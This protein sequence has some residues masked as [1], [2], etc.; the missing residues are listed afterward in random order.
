MPGLVAYNEPYRPGSRPTKVNTIGLLTAGIQNVKT[1]VYY[2]LPH[3]QLLQHIQNSLACAV[4]K[5]PKFSH[6]TPILKSLNWLKVNERIEYKILSHIQDS[7]HTAQ[8]ADLHNLIS[9]QPPGRTRSSSLIIIARP[10]PSSSSLKITDRSFRY[11]SHSLWNNLPVSFRQPHLSSVTNITPSITSSL[12]HSR[13]KT[14]LFPQILS[15]NPPDCQ[16]YFNRCLL[17]TSP[18]PRD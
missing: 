12:F 18:S 3:S 14:H 5:A 15:T 4:V 8:P 11:A 10:A 17:Y 16:L 2:D 9:V 1:C 13:L 6:T 7:L